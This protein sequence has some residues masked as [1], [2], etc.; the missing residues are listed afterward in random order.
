MSEAK[1]K[2][3]NIYDV[4][5]EISSEYDRYNFRASI[6]NTSKGK[7]V[8]FLEFKWPEDLQS[9]FFNTMIDVPLSGI[10]TKAVGNCLMIWER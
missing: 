6:F 3:T 5:K 8:L 1:K 9:F 4:W 10:A 7:R 2:I